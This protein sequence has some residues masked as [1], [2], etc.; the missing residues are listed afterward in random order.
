MDSVGACVSVLIS[1]FI[2]KIH[3]ILK[4]RALIK[5]AFKRNSFWIAVDLGG[6]V[7]LSTVSHFGRILMGGFTGFAAGRAI[8]GEGSIVGTGLFGGSL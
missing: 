5:R 1:I 2:V 8:F 6:G 4:F 3:D 7:T